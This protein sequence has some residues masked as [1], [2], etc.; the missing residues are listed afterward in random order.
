MSARTE[1][2]LLA[3]I[4]LTHREGDDP[5][6]SKDIAARASI[7][8]PFLDQLLLDL[9]RAGL[10]RSVRGPGGGYVLAR[11]AGEITLKDAIAA[12]EGGALATT[13]GIKAADGAP[14]R[15][16]STCALLEVWRELD[17]AVVGIL[18][19]TTLAGLAERQK[20]LDGQQM[21]YI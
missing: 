3:L 18:T 15:K 1:Y 6:Q 5:L 16:L 8:K 21:Y 11:P 4:E 10:V 13:C 14:C 19:R 12:V 9:R 7:P 20:R 17:E 2:A